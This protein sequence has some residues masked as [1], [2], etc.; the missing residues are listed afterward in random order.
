MN[1]VVIQTNDIYNTEKIFI[2]ST[3]QFSPIE[4]PT[5]EG[6]FEITFRAAGC[7]IGISEASNVTLVKLGGK[8]LC[9][10]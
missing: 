10:S 9:S 4:I 2:F 5:E 7:S 8:L 6:Q 1:Y 3:F